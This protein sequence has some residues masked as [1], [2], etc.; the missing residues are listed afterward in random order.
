MR[1]VASLGL[2]GLFACAP[3]LSE[4]EQVSERPSPLLEVDA[5][6]PPM[7]LVQVEDIAVSSGYDAYSFGHFGRGRACVVAD[8]DIDGTLDV[9]LGNPGDE[10]FVMFGASGPQG[11]S[12][13]P[14][15]AFSEEGAFWAAASADY[16]ND[17]DADIFLA[18]G[19]NEEPGLD[20]LWENQTMDGDPGV[21]E[22][23][24]DEA[25]VAGFQTPLGPAPQASAGANWADFDND[26]WV[27]L[28]VSSNRMP[29]IA[30]A[31]LPPFLGLNILW[32][33]MGDGTFVNVGP[34]A[35]LHSQL[36]TRHSQWIDFD[37]D[38]DQD[39]L[40][41]NYKEQNILWRN[42]LV[43][44]GVPTFVNVSAN[45]SLAGNFLGHPLA[46]FSSAVD[47]FNND[48]WIDLL[49][50]SRPTGDCTLDPDPGVEE[51]G[52][53]MFINVQ[54]TGFV[55]VTP[56]TQLNDNFIANLGVM[57]SSTGDVN[58]D[59][60]PDVFIAN[61]GP[62][63]GQTDQLLVSSGTTI[64]DIV[65][66]GEVIVPV[67]DDWTDLLDFPAEEVAGRGDYP[68]YP[69]RGHGTCMTDLDGVQHEIG[70]RTQG[71]HKL[72]HK[73]W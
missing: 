21:F 34:F 28:L 6:L 40:E 37:N 73:T 66:V 16:D 44:T 13:E 71:Q 32:R 19:G 55:D 35:G 18:G 4:G 10:T 57:G 67:F 56:Y 48:G 63:G 36:S 72:P 12:F 23:V 60:L 29:S 59:G 14:G 22:D 46:S 51:V 53:T 20:M 27:D 3:P 5:P 7:A 61:G 1:S 69:Y 15:Q 2:L 70:V 62:M 45:M 33:N 64:V 38:G 41:N 58:A 26:G 54:G 65:D 25:G 8:Y 52:H 30:A 24:T 11:L 17:G 50:F 43:E 42:M 9:L 68:P 39:I 47:D 49:Y 31:Q